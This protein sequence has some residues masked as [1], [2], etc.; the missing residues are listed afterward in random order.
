MPQFA[1]VAK[2]RMGNTVQGTLTA[3][4]L[5]FAANQIGQMGYSL[6]DLQPVTTPSLPVEAGSAAPAEHTQS[7]A[8][9]STS[10]QAPSPQNISL[11]EPTQ[12]LP[13]QPSAP[14]PSPPA[15]VL[16]ADA[17]RRMKLEQDLIKMGMKAEEIRRLLDAKAN[18]SDPDAGPPG[19]N[20]G[21]GAR[22]MPSMPLSPPAAPTGRAAVSQRRAAREADLHSFAAELQSNAAAAQTRAIEA[23]SQALPAFRESSAQ[24]IRQAEQ[25]LR[26]ASIARRREKF[27][28]AEAKCRDAIALVP[29]DAAALELLGDLLQGVARTEEALAAYRRALEADPKRASAERKYGDLLARQQNW[30]AIDPEAVP[31]NPL[32]AT[33]LSLLLPG[34]GQIYNGEWIKGTIIMACAVLCVLAWFYI[35][36]QKPYEATPAKANRPAVTARPAR[37][38]VNLDVPVMISRVF[39][40]L[41][42]VYSAADAG[43]AARRSKNG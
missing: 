43:A 20:V 1:F 21:R 9:P 28:E 15:D 41:L 34:S 32:V 5:A 24:E 8:S 38:K 13:A 31:K 3:A 7:F 23:A 18:T 39:Y 19:S 26:E 12:N 2:D 25:L 29:K 14:S 42:L 27:R 37:S 40:V 16:Q 6:V 11:E 33:M 10:T 36:P 4:D 35:G 17:A 30:N 22:A